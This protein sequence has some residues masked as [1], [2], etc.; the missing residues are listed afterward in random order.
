MT[1]RKSHKARG[2]NFESNIRDYFRS[3]GYEAERLSRTGKNDEGDVT[4]WDSVHGL[5]YV[6]ECKA[7]GEAGRIDLSGWSQEARVE[8]ENYAKARALGEDDL[9]PAAVL[10]KARGKSIQDS[11][12]VF[13]LGDFFHDKS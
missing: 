12:L 13:R 10:I 6:F 4:V 11:Y 5:R 8:R 9:A 7:P 1:T 2:A 3:M